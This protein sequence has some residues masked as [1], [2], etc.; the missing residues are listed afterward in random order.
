MMSVPTITY[1]NGISR[2]TEFYYGS[3][4][5][6]QSARYINT[7]ENTK[8]VV[9]LNNKGQNRKIDLTSWMNLTLIK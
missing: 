6:S 5:L 2:K 8:S 3:S 1:K 4:Y 7:D 9:I